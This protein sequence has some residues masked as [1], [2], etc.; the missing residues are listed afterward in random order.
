MK[1][2]DE[3]LDFD[4]EA[5]RAKYRAERDKR[6]REDGNSQYV[7]TDGEFSYLLDDPQADRRFSRALLTDQVEVVVVGGGYS[8]LLVGAR[9][10]QAGIQ[11]VRI[12]ERGA[13][14]GGVWYWNRYPG[15]A[16]DVEAYT[17]MPLLEETG[18]MPRRRFSEGEEIRE[19]CRKIA[20]TFDLYRDACFQTSVTGMRWDEATGLWTVSTS[21]GDAMRAKFVVVANFASLNRPKLPGVPGLHDFKGKAFHTARWDYDYT[22]GGPHGGL[23]KL[24]DKV[25]GIIGTGASAVQCIPH[26]AYGA[27]RLYVFQR[28][29]A[30][31]DWRNDRPTDPEWV[32]SLEPGWQKKRI[33]NFTVLTSG[34]YAEEDLI[35]DA[36]TQSVASVNRTIR[37]L[38]EAGQEVEDPER[39]R[40]LADYKKMEEIRRRVDAVVE[41][42]EWAEQLKPYYDQFCKRPC[43]HDE[44][45]DV[46][47]RP[48]VT[49]VDTDGKGIDRI[50]AAGVVAKGEEYKLDCLIYASGFDVFVAFEKRIGYPIHGRDGLELGASW[51]DGALTHH[52][53]MSHGFPNCFV[54]SMTQSGRTFNNV[55]LY[56]E[57]AV[58]IAYVIAEAKRRK[59]AW[60]EPDR[61]AQEIWLA[62][63]DRAAPDPTAF[64]RECTPS[65]NNFEGDVGAYNRRNVP[66]GAGPIAYFKLLEAWRAQGDMAGLEKTPA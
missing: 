63:V 14:F 31:I 41:N 30:S 51:R 7:A 54:M 17:Y 13:E 33:D 47:N 45:L 62:E 24:G 1:V 36:L 48:N 8:G 57:H 21:R 46:F 28:T 56:S 22:G 39:F 32:K 64:L 23:D 55:H 9:L 5:L 37:L 18:F 65:Y 16:C 40:Q 25:V 3:G 53:L 12:I 26:L 59:L 43:S 35:Q 19:H 20:E 44:Y 38:R 11:S 27:R 61:E 60:V 66:Y 29:P 10:R 42:K 58:H 50:T 4:P 34:G 2:I 49:L 15:I 6:L 52:G